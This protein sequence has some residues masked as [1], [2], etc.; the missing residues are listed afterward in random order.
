MEGKR[1]SAMRLRPVVQDARF[2]EQALPT[3]P[4]MTLMNMSPARIELYQA[5]VKASNADGYSENLKQIVE[6]QCT[7]RISKAYEYLKSFD[8]IQIT[9]NVTK[10]GRPLR[11]KLDKEAR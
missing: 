7:L 6:T 3:V 10:Q 1:L 5:I 11:I 9:R 4:E 8:N 2:K